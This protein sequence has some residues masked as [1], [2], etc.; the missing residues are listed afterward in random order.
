MYFYSEIAH[1]VKANEY[2]TAADL[3]RYLLKL[4]DTLT[5]VAIDEQK[6]WLVSAVGIETGNKDDKF[7]DDVFE[8]TNLVSFLRYENELK[9]GIMYVKTNGDDKNIRVIGTSEIPPQCQC[10]KTFDI[11]P[12]GHLVN[13]ELF[14]KQVYG[15]VSSYMNKPFSICL[16]RMNEIDFAERLQTMGIAVM[17]TITTDHFIWMK[18]ARNE[19]L[20]KPQMLS[21]CLLCGWCTFIVFPVVCVVL[22]SYFIDG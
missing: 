22:L 21:I 12:L 13:E 2:A 8:K 9:N 7:F 14:N 5:A 20:S 17:E 3:K 6:K 10:E 18:C 15:I 19:S 16:P 1:W 4:F 11:A